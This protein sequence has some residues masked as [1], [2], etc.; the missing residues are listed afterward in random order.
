MESFPI[1]QPKNADELL[2]SIYF[3]LTR[4]KDDIELKRFGESFSILLAHITSLDFENRKISLDLVKKLIIKTRDIIHGKGE[5]DLSYI[6][7]Y[8]LHGEFP[9]ETIALIYEIIPKHGSWR[10]VPGLCDF[11]RRSS[12]CDHPIIKKTIEYANRMLHS[13]YK[14]V[15][16]G[17]ISNVAKWIPREN[18]K[19]H[20]L[21]EL[22]SEHWTKTYTPYIFTSMQ[23]K[24]S[25]SDPQSCIKAI[26]K[27]RYLYRKVFVKLS[28]KLD[29]VESKM[30]NGAWASITPEKLNCG[31]F[32]KSLDA[33]IGFHHENN[34]ER[35][36]CR[37]R[38]VFSLPMSNAPVRVGELVKLCLKYNTPT[39][40]PQS[41][42]AE[43]QQSAILIRLKIL[44]ELWDF[45]MQRF[46]QFCNN[47]PLCLPLICISE[48]MVKNQ[49]LYTAVGLGLWIAQQSP[50]LHN[51]INRRCKRILFLC[52]QP[53]WKQIDKP[54][55]SSN[56]MSIFKDIP[57]PT[58]PNILAG[59]SLIIHAIIHSN[60]SPQEIREM[61]FV[62]ICDM[63]FSDD[64]YSQI[65]QLFYTTG[66]QSTYKTPFPV[67]HFVYWNVSGSH[68]NFNVQEKN[69]LFLSGDSV[70]TFRKFTESFYTIAH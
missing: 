28:E 55:F 15:A 35:M 11:V 3:D 24:N 59:I 5:R 30:C 33:F 12:T 17:S 31:T 29:L 49:C 4:K 62:V 34:V 18:S 40:T 66:V 44:N 22:M 41:R 1:L 45:H 65:S 70:S 63:D 6:M 26:T 42:A 32:M 19:N 13:D 51:G 50:E 60:I 48:S 14:G 16:D 61:R 69:V 47:V 67:P 56:I 27:S 20:W 58:R 23:R 68:V 7:L 25:Q 10:D 21:F 38:I 39:E 36:I 53:Y 46:S 8:L 64:L 57:P 52:N 9:E 37:E 54:D 2:N 43:L